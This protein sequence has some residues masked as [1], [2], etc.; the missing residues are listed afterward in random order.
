[1][2]S[3][4][5][6]A[7]LLTSVP[8]SSSSA[9]GWG[10]TRMRDRGM[11]GMRGMRGMARGMRRG[12]ARGMRTQGAAQGNPPRR[13][14]TAVLI[15]R[16]RAVLARDPRESFAFQRLL[17]LY[18]ERDGNVDQLVTE[19]EAQVAGDGDA[20]APRML[21]GHLYKAQNRAGEARR[22]YEQAA[23]LRP[24]DPAPRV[25]MANIDRAD[26]PARSRELF[27][28]ALE[29]TTDAQARREL[30][31]ELGSIALDQQ[32]WDGARGYYEQL[33]RG[34]G[35]SI[36]LRSELARALAERN[37]HERA[38]AEYQRVLTSLRGDNRVIGPV[39]RDLAQAQLDA[40]QS[41]DAIET[42]NRA[43][44]VAGARSGVRREI[45]DVLALAYRRTDRLPE[46]AERLARARDFDAVE[47]L[48][49]VH[50][51]LGNEEDALAAYR[52]ALRM[53]RRHID[54][55][56]RIIQLLSRSG[57]I[58]DVI[59]E[60]RELV[61]AAPR[62][63]RFVVE[64]AQ[65][66]MQVG[67]REEALRIADQ[68]S[69]QH[70]RDPGVHQ[71]LA[72]LYTRWGEDERATREIAML[73]RID[74]RDPG[75]LIALGEQQLEEGKREQALAT[76]R[77][78]LTVDSDRGRANATLAAVL[79]DNDFLQD[80]ERHYRRA[81]EAS[82]D[83]VEYLR[84]LASILERPQRGE[85][86]HERRARDE[87]AA[88]WW[89]KVL[90]VSSDRAARREAR[91]RI[92]GI[93][94]RRRELQ[95]RIRTWL[96]AFSGT[97]PDTEA[98]RFLAEAYLR[99][100]PRNVER[101]EATF[102]RIVELE[103]GDVES[104]LGFERVRMAQGDLAGAI[105]VLRR[106]VEADPRRA[107]RYLQRMAEHAHALYRDEDAIRYAAEA[108]SRTPD[109]A[110]GHRRL[111]DLYRAR[112]NM[113]R[114]IAS[115]RRAIELNERLFTTYFDLAELHLARGEHQDADRLYRGV[116]RLSPDDDLVARAGRAA[117]QVHL[118]E[119]TLEE[120]ERDLLPL[121]LGHPRRPIFRRLL[122]E[123]YDSLAGSWIQQARGSGDEAAAARASLDRLGVRA[124]KPLLE[125]LA[126]DDPSQQRIAVDVLGHLGNEN[127]AG[128]LLAMAE[129]ESVLELRARAL[130]GAGSLAA[131]SFASRFVAIARGTEHR[132]R[133]IATWSLAR[134]GG[135][136]ALTALRD[137]VV[138]GDPAVRAY[139]ALGL[140]RAGDRRSVATLERLLR[141]DRSPHVQAASAWSLGR[142]GG[143]D[144]IPVLVTALR[145]GGT[146]SQAAAQAL[147]R[148]GRDRRDDRAY[149]ALAEA[150]FD[151]DAHLR[152]G[153]A[154]ALGSRE[155]TSAFPVP[156]GHISGYLASLVAPTTGRG[157]VDLDAAMPHLTRAA[158][159]SLHGPV[160]RVLTALRVLSPVGDTPVGLGP[161]TSDLSSWSE[162]SQA[163]ASQRLAQLGRDLA[164]DLAEVV[165]HPEPTA[166]EL[167][168][169]LLARAVPDAAGPALARALRDDD[170]RVLRAALDSIDARH[171]GE[172]ALLGR[173]MELAETH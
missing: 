20:F 92:V 129:G 75:H 87:E 117:V 94:S 4:L 47:L 107:P 7:L 74:P 156:T 98:G 155:A 165:T 44:R 72:E 38:I 159:D 134:M 137:L 64:L 61:R 123:L 76:W 15:A 88:R 46:L 140:G 146:T 48:G 154:Q 120:L 126:D 6:L 66:L 36:Y 73:V 69:R 55:R 158:R 103:P 31:R 147:G 96:A 150:L 93:W 161:L 114:A 162:D 57:R 132:L 71:A 1:M 67:R 63:P 108:V 105:E 168:I 49:R 101:A 84:G 95:G 100:R 40:G 171:A 151:P 33:A 34:A 60:Y 26:S 112:Q 9:Q 127:A 122:V 14:R 124:I 118:G 21:L 102:A 99:M 128:P 18:R 115:Y 160:E 145:R 157:D 29:R 116:L 139:A 167:G 24:R 90:E 19:L 141:E 78:I 85:R 91:Q 41:D 83:R 42:L 166:R 163:A 170:P 131:P 27:E 110:E 143:A 80:A 70:G 119:G 142:A 121:A 12:M 144:Q 86:P 51:E 79:A 113:D 82:P 56:V 13:D 25:A 59:A 16:Y 172:E 3:I 50:D 11:Q 2:R 89:G 136:N 152:Q 97:P 62:E 5:A 32:D 53:N 164:P 173:V 8:L 35:T 130:A 65:L 17:D 10:L 45:Y 43:L 138:R 81:V 52:R 23:T 68:T 39:L 169:M 135:T 22:L 148:L 111:G 58:D 77:R 153:A 149:A 28:A 125:A 109:D 106:L 30:L 104:L 54:T 133:G 37:Q